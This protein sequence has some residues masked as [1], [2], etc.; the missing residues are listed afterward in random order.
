MRS[1]IFRNTFII[2]LIILVCMGLIKVN[3][4]NTKA[5]S[6]LGNTNANY[7]L[8][9]D[10]FGDDFSNFIKDNSPMKIY[11]DKS[12]ETLIR[13]WDK[14]FKISDELKVGDWVKKTIS[15]IKELF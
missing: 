10:E 9:R 3:I 2:V 11:V 1:K 8:V 14:D 6:P 12:K 13:V 5:L 15:N 7:A 4:I